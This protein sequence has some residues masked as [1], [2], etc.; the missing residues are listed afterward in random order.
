MAHSASHDCTVLHWQLY[1]SEAG[2]PWQNRGSCRKENLY[3]E[4]DTPGLSI[5]VTHPKGVVTLPKTQAV[6]G[7]IWITMVY[8]CDS[9]QGI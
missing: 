9:D 3:L 6:G 4:K 8:R 2:A 7:D 5:T 1:A